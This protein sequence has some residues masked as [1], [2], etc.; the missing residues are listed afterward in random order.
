MSAGSNGHHP[1]DESGA[2]DTI[3]TPP[4]SYGALP[5]IPRGQAQRAFSA[6][7]DDLSRAFLLVEA[8]GM[9]ACRQLDAESEDP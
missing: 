5:P 1:P 2:H 6:A 8:L 4:P 3:P 9:A 7:L